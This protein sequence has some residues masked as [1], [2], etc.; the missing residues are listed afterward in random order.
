MLNRWF[1]WCWEKQCHWFSEQY[2]SSRFVWLKTD[3]TQKILC[4][5]TD[6]VELTSIMS[7]KHKQTEANKG[8]MNWRASLLPLPLLSPSPRECSIAQQRGLELDKISCVTRLDFQPFW[9]IQLDSQNG[10]TLNLWC[11]R[12]FILYIFC[13]S[14]AIYWFSGKRT[15]FVLTKVD[16]AEQNDANPSRVWLFPLLDFILRNLCIV[17]FI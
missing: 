4:Y 14:Y 10:W 16:L 2:G 8:K 5:I 7:T 6:L 11:Y 3:L 13:M 1:H 17:S 12:L 9:P 15:I